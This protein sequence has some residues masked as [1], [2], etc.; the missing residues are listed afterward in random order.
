MTFPPYFGNRKV[1]PPASVAGDERLLWI[2]ET[3]RRR[4]KADTSASP[5]K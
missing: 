2:C 1:E 4:N 3:I 5:S